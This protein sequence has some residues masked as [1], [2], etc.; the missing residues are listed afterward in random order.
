M[1][2]KSLVAGRPWMYVANVSQ[3]TMT[4]YLPKGKNTGAAA[5]AFPG[6][7]FKF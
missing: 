1:V 6:E 4:V 2:N 5:V 3:P 7:A